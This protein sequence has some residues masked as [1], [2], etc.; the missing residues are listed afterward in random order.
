[1]HQ[2]GWGEGRLEVA[3]ICT[4]DD[5]IIHFSLGI[6]SWFS[7]NRGSGLWAEGNKTPSDQEVQRKKTVTRVQT[8]K[9]SQN[10]AS[11]AKGKEQDSLGSKSQHHLSVPL[12]ESFN[13]SEPPF[14]TL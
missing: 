13:L 6:I 5:L 14:P 3:G 11:T 9:L 4:V 1:M 12:T 2:V 8:A 7:H 10:K